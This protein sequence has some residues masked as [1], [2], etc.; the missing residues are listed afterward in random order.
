MLAYVA[1]RI[2]Y[3]IPIVICVAFVCFVLVH[4]TLAAN[5][6]G[7]FVLLGSGRSKRSAII[8]LAAG[9]TQSAFA[10]LVAP[11]GLMVMASNRFL[12]A[13]ITSLLYRAARFRSA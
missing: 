8:V 4:I 6:G 12:Y 9:A 10:A 3:V 1:R 5:I 7:Y 2:V 11:L 13:I